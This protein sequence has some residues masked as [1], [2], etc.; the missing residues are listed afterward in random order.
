MHK[1]IPDSYSLVSTID[2]S[3]LSQDCVDDL[4]CRTQS[5][6]SNIQKGKEM[7]SLS[8]SPLLFSL[9]SQ[10]E[11]YHLVLYIVCIGFRETCLMVNLVKLQEVSLGELLMLK[12]NTKTSRMFEIQCYFLDNSKKCPPSVVCVSVCLFVCVCVCVCVYVCMHACMHACVC[13]CVV[14]V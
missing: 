8:L 2:G 12:A 7:R 11:S 6:W 9:Q 14:L 4:L 1:K 13:V 3:T 10:I 5:N